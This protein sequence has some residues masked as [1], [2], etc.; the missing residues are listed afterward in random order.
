MVNSDKLL[1]QILDESNRYLELKTEISSKIGQAA[2]IFRFMEELLPQTVEKFW[3]GH[4]F[5]LTEANHELEN[6]IQLCK[7]GFYKHALTALRS[8]LELGLLSVYWDLEDQGH[9]KMQKWL[10]SHEYTP[11]NKSVIESLKTNKNIKAFDAKHNFFKDIK[12]LFELSSYVHTRGVDYSY[13]DLSNGGKNRFKETSF[14]KWLDFFLRVVK[15]V[16]ISHVLK[17]PIAL[18]YTPL[19]QK[20]GLNLPA[21]GFLEPYQSEAIKEF[22]D[23]DVVKT[24]QT[25]SDSDDTAVTEAKLINA[26]PDITTE[27]MQKQVDEFNKEYTL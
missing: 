25:I 9:V 3:S 4:M 18:Q 13:N 24:L 21:G 27:E 22:L 19:D 15:I 11:S 12:S 5:P 10:R 7:M 8:T 17:Y 6:S 14:L 23:E 2:L 20:F 26:Q 1:L 16:V